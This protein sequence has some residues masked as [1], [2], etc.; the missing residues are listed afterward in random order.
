MHLARDPLSA[1]L[2]LVFN[3]RSMTRLGSYIGE[4]RL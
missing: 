2:T 1:V 4:P 3:D